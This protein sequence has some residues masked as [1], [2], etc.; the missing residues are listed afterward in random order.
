MKWFALGLIIIFPL[1]PSLS[2]LGSGGVARAG[3]YDNSTI[4]TAYTDYGD[5]GSYIS[6]T[7]LIRVG[8]SSG[9]SR[10]TTVSTIATPWSSWSDNRVQRHIV[11][12][13]ESVKSISDRYDVSIDAILW[14]NDLSID[15]ELQ[16]GQILNIPPISGVVHTVADG[17]TISEIAQRYSVSTS[18][19]VSVNQLRDAA[20]I[21]IGMDLM[22]PGAIKRTVAKADIPPPKKS[23]TISV[24][25][26]TPRPSTTP[27]MGSAKT[28]LKERY[29]VKYTGKTRGFVWGNCTAYVAQN[30]TVTWRGNA[31]AWIK[32]ARAAGEKTGK[33]PVVGAIVQFSGAGYNPYYGHVGIVAGIEGG[34]IIVKDMNYRWL[35]EITIRRVSQ[36]D[37]TIDGYIYVD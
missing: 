18:D 24:P 37:P 2:F 8:G 11:R 14:A 13:K 31:N 10:P 26:P 25:I 27:T 34:D 19:I 29:I 3:N 20:S 15:D 32:N 7:G 36:D 16:V 12:A 9:E 5:D 30:K 22:I 28:G 23:S 4:I 17:D 35:Y 6:D 33:I 21:R 1:Y